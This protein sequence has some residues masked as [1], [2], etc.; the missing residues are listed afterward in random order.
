MKLLS[1]E[2]I[3]TELIL[4]L[5]LAITVTSRTVISVAVLIRVRKTKKE[6]AS[7]RFSPKQTHE[8]G[9]RRTGTHVD[10]NA[11]SVCDSPAAVFSETREHNTDDI[12]IRSNEAYAAITVRDLEDSCNVYELATAFAT[13]SGTYEEHD[14]HNI[15]EI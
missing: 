7:T 5:L 4:S 2:N 15:Y 11:E 9:T 1:T 3:A 12:T 13:E 8:G 10:N 14:Y 6:N